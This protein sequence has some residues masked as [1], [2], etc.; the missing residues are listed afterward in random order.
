[1]LYVCSNSTSMCVQKAFHRLKVSTVPNW[2]VLDY[3]GQYCSNTS[4]SNIKLA[5]L[6][7]HFLYLFEQSSST[8]CTR[9]LFLIWRT[10]WG[11][12]ALRSRSQRSSRKR[13]GTCCQTSFPQRMKMASRRWTTADLQPVDTEPED[14]HEEKPLSLLYFVWLAE[15][16][17]VTSC[18][19]G[20]GICYNRYFEWPDVFRMRCF[21][22]LISFEL[23]Q[24]ETDG[25]SVH[26]CGSVYW[27][28]IMFECVTLKDCCSCSD[29]F[30]GMTEPSVII[31]RRNY[32]LCVCRH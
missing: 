20:T 31:S 27:L 19:R 2:T 6:W 13:I 15:L 29:Q 22:F 8:S 16:C 18:W 23:Q 14:W 4:V 10:N 32:F 26:N 30:D 12:W 28:L 25:G 1:M 7:C 3:G 21:I 17:G 5:L 24:S 11:N 9:R